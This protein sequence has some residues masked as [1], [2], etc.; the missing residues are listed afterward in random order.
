MSE[1]RERIYL[2][3]PFSE[4]NSVKE[5]GASWDRVEKKWWVHA[6][7]NLANLRRWLPEEYQ[8]K[9]EY[10]GDPRVEFADALRAFGLHLRG[11]PIMDGKL[12]RVPVPGDVGRATGGAYV[13]YLDGVPS[14]FI[15][16][17]RDGTECNWRSGSVAAEFTP[18]E[19]ERMAAEVAESRRLRAE[20]R[21]EATFAAANVAETAWSLARPA[22]ADH[23]YLV[24]KGIEPGELRV[25]AKGQT[26]PTIGSEGRLK[27]FSVEG[28]LF[29]PLRDNSGK[30]WSI[31]TIDAEGTK[32]FQRGGRIPAC[33]T[34]IGELKPDSPVIIAEGYATASSV[35]KATGLPVIAAFTAWNIIA[36]AKAYREASN[37]RP[38]IIAAD[39]DHLKP[40]EKNI[41]RLK[42][43][44]AAVEV[45]GVV[46]L[47][48]F[49]PTEKW[50]DWNDYVKIHGLGKAGMD[51]RA[52]VEAAR[53]ELKDVLVAPK[54]ENAAAEVVTRE[55]RT[56]APKQREKQTII[57]EYWARLTSSGGET[58]RA[59]VTKRTIE[60]TS[61]LALGSRMRW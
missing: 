19:L 5:L 13:G 6:D 7:V 43:E 8:P 2:S 59:S 48:T 21:R 17:W 27:E 4:K 52:A 58:Q 47:P 55:L 56:E 26:M 36:V 24:K 33:H 54:T 29:V 32:M 14:G 9:V 31:Q 22:P 15:Q 1:T 18:A 25:G 49:A 30:L 11:L 34:V 57:A 37:E 16:N 10:K 28:R 20:E 44:A 50:N 51:F 35:H 42:A 53:P 45:N 40:A 60:Q 12:H 38:I 3:V 41:G 46:A 61:E 39:N 23:P